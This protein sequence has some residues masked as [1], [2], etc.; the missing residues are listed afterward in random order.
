MIRSL[1][2]TTQGRLHSKGIQ[3]FLMPTFIS[4]TKWL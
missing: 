3:M 4:D 2:F 1:V